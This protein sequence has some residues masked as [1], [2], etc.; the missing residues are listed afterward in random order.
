MGDLHGSWTWPVTSLRGRIGVVLYG[1]LT[2]GPLCLTQG[3][4]NEEVW[5]CGVRKGRR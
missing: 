4:N 3:L 2:S 1:I 5:R